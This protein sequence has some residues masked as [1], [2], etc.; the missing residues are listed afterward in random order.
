MELSDRFAIN[1]N[2]AVR[3]VGEE[4]VI[5]DLTS[6]TYLGLDPVGAR[7]WQLMGEGMTLAQICSVMLDEYEV[8]RADLERDTMNLV[9]EL[10]AQE[11]ISAS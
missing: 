4:T 1:P 9:E 7:I 10:S 6:G 3:Q 8:A 2:V 5:L 11:L